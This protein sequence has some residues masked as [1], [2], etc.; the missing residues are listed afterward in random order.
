MGEVGSK[1][2][3]VV[4]ELPNRSLIFGIPEIWSSWS[5]P[6]PE[7]MREKKREALANTAQG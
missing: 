2:A 4:L 6:N 3:L 1:V 5:E 7:L